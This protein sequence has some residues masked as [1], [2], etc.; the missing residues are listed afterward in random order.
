MN[1]TNIFGTIALISST[2]GL[3]PQVYK[4][5]ITK[6]TKG[7]SM[8]M[9]VNCLIGATAWIIHG[10]YESERFIVLSN[11]ASLLTSITLITQKIYYDNHH[12]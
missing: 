1:I 6:S 9:L 12:Q 11:I 7:V 4:S 2:I 5:Y 8:L 10:H 3:W